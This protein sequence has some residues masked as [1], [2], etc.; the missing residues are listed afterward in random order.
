MLRVLVFIG[1]AAGLAW[2]VHS[3]WTHAP[4]LT[5]TRV[6][7]E[8]P[9]AQ[10]LEKALGVRPGQPLWSFSAR[11][12]AQHLLTLFPHLGE[13]RVSRTWTRAVRV[14]G[15]PRAA[16]ARRLDADRW[17]GVDI[18]G[19]SFPLTDAGTGLLIF[20]GSADPA[21]TGRAMAWLTDL[22]KTKEPWTESLYKIKMSSDGD[23][24]LFL[25]GDT[26]V[27]WGAPDRSEEILGP[28]ARRLTKVMAAPEGAA[29]YDTLRFVDDRRVVAHPRA[30]D[31]GRPPSP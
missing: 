19:C 23:L 3:L 17:M 16:V 13:V 12:R 15:I 20:T 21:A 14:T 24:L 7:A 30:S 25:T 8:G 31:E 11:E 22:R 1:S 28:K 4:G 9:A 27:F 10:E 6:V 5:V 26:R 2:G 29:G 18:A